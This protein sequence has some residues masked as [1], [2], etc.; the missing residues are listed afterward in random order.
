VDINFLAYTLSAMQNGCMPLSNVAYTA[1]LVKEV[2]AKNQ[3][4]FYRLALWRNLFGEVSLM[5]EYGRLGQKG[6]HLRFDL[7]HDE[8]KAIEAFES[9]LKQKRRRGYVPAGP[10]RL[11][12]I[13]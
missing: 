4:R 10:G 9:L 8:E 1:E 3:A 7:F 12:G 5:R 2:P 13:R 11:S 6:G